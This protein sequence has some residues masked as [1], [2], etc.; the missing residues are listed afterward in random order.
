MIAKRLNG[1]PWSP[2]ELCDS[3]G[4][5]EKCGHRRLPEVSPNQ[6]VLPVSE[7]FVVTEEIGRPQVH[8]FF[9]P[10]ILAIRRAEGERIAR[11]ERDV[12]RFAKV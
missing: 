11:G 12:Y 4:P 1:E 6:E 7:S 10:L 3:C 5:D 8:F 9:A 2:W